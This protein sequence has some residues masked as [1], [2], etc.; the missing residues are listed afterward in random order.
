MKH[1]HI[2]LLVSE[3]DLVTSDNKV[4]H[5]WR[6]ESSD[7]EDLLTE[8]S[9]HFRR[10]YCSDEDLD[11]L[12]EGYGYTREQFLNE[13]KFPSCSALG[14]ATRSGD[15]CEILVADFAQY[16]LNYYVPRTRYD[17]KVNPD[18]STQGSDMLGFKVGEKISSS[19]ELLVFEVKGRATNVK[20]ENR[21]Q[22]AIDDS[23]KDVKR[24][25]FS[26][27]A[28]YQRLLEKH[29]YDNAKKVQRFQNVTDRP[30]RTT[31]AA[32]AV[33][34]DRSFSEELTKKVDTKEHIDPDIYL[35]VIHRKDL[36]DFIHELYRR[37]SKC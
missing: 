7:D 5:I 25:T 22:K 21:L 23:K 26:L 12:R 34:S 14:N 29:E 19:D 28:I 35:L 24:I 2:E 11:V 8:W 36:M 16:I 4:V 17:R 3:K 32:A 20:P 13:I 9:T 37:A 18:S 33:Q 6:L 10:H 31:F 15:F 27:N 30:Y 1:K